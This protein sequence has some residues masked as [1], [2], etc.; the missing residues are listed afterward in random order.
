MGTIL[1]AG[2]IVDVPIG[3]VKRRLQSIR[4]AVFQFMPKIELMRIRPAIASTVKLPSDPVFQLKFTLVRRG[5]F[6]S[7]DEVTLRCAN[8]RN[9]TKNKHGRHDT[10][11]KDTRFSHCARL[12]EA[13]CVRCRWLANF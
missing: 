13:R 11:E 7:E 4:D 2:M 3:E 8:A 12:T 6:I 9:A 5:D 1:A 10:G